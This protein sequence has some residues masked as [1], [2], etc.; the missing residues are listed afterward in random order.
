MR[1]TI[2]RIPCVSLGDELL[3]RHRAQLGPHST[4]LES[5]NEGHIVTIEREEQGVRF[6]VL[7]RLGLRGNSC[8]IP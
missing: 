1:I 7:H 4:E 3:V 6:V 5:V 8:R 2:F